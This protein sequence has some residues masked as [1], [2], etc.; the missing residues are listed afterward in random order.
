ML[1]AIS[2]ANRAHYLA[3]GESR[4]AAAPNGWA[5]TIMQQQLRLRAKKANVKKARAS[6]ALA[7]HHC[8]SGTCAPVRTTLRL[9]EEEAVEGASASHAGYDSVVF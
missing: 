2:L 5:A 4:D 8:S 7:F 1:I 6:S 3:A 9:D